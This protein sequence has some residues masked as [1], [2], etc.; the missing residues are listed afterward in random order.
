[1]LN[2]R[3]KDYKGKNPIRIVL[4]YDLEINLTCKLLASA[5][6]IKTIIYTNHPNLLSEKAQSLKNHNIEIRSSKSQAGKFI[7]KDILKELKA[8]YISV[9]MVEAGP[10]LVSS[11]VKE[12]LVDKLYYFIAPCLIGGGNSAFKD[13]G[14]AN[15]SA[16][17]ELNLFSSEIIDGDILLVYYFNKNKLVEL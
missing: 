11:F 1:M 8:E 12:N 10:R 3:L 2:V 6:E 14:V 16:K 13:I 9:V 7:I 17:K 5:R 4:D 15:I